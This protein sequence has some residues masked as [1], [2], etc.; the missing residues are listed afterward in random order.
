M[1]L[2]KA[3]SRPRALD[4]MCSAQAHSRERASGACAAEC[5]REPHVNAHIVGCARKV[6]NVAVSVGGFASVFDAVIPCEGRYK[7]MS[8]PTAISGGVP[9]IPAPAWTATNYR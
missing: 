5:H 9:T 4:S 1:D 2:W 3:S 6:N 8:G 7:V